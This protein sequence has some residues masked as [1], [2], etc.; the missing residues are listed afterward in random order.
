[1]IPFAISPAVERDIAAV[2][3]LERACFR[4]AWSANAFRE[5][6]GAAWIY[7]ACARR[8]DTGALVGYVV[9]S[10][11]AD[12]GEVT[13]LAVD[14]ASRRSG[15]GGRL[16]DAVMREAR[17][18][19]ASALYLEVRDSNAAGRALYRSHGFTEVG[20]RRDYYRFPDEDAIVLR[21]DLVAAIERAFRRC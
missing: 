15:L 20:R 21:L 12:E 19:G 6:L 11:A 18:R 8:S 17:Q 4:D 1:M 3:A 13:N 10:F 2:A 14:P 16:L 5:V 7:F 9:A